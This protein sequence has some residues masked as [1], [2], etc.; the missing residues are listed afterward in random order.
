MDVQKVRQTIIVRILLK[1]LR[2]G[3]SYVGKLAIL[4]GVIRVNKLTSA[5]YGIFN[6]PCNINNIDL[7]GLRSEIA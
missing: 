7:G 4:A 3:H 6:I 1:V 2:L 5:T